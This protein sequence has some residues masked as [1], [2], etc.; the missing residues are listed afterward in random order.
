MVSRNDI[1]SMN[2]NWKDSLYSKYV[3]SGQAGRNSVEKPTI[4]ASEFI[5]F[6]RAV[7]PLLPDDKT[8]HV[9]DLGCGYGCL[10]KCLKSWGYKSLM[11]VDASTE[12]VALAQQYGI[13]EVRHG[14]IFDESIFEDKK[15]DVVFL[16]D[17]IEH[18][19]RQEIFDLLSIL[20]SH[21][22]P[23]GLLIMHVPNALGVFGNSIRYGDLTHEIAFT[24]RSIQQCLTASGFHSVEVRE[25]KPIPHGLKSALR[26][27]LWEIGSLPFRIL[28]AAEVG[29]FPLALSQNMLVT[30]L[31]TPLPTEEA[32]AS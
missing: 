2:R 16:M 23:H 12:Q 1:Q 4:D 9:V 28:Y 22:S 32:T 18:L 5:Y 20:R 17:V 25:D 15:A 19:N 10:L 27:L 6:E 24:P 31:L 30:A 7:R 29:C 13:S 11:G 26:R 21:M 14:S 8:V 3:S